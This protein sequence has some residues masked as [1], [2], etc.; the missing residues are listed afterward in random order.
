VG[1]SC[2]EEEVVDADATV[3]STEE[4]IDGIAD[5]EA[6]G[7]SLWGKQR[8][9]QETKANVHYSNRNTAVIGYIPFVVVGAIALKYS[10]QSPSGV[11]ETTPVAA[12]EAAV[13]L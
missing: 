13:S 8:N 10:W 1:L 3:E 5:L 6:L 7:A 9:S 11:A 2:A 12:S 4:V